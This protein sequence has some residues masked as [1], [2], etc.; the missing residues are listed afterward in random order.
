VTTDQDDLDL[1]D[2]EA[3]ALHD[4]QLG[5]EYVHRAYGSLLEWH[6]NLGHA[7]DR[8][9]DAEA[10]LRKAGH[11]RWADELRDEH[12]PAGAIDDRWTYELVE[13]FQQDFF[14]DVVAF[15]EAVREDVA[16]GVGH[17]TEQQQ[18]RRVRKR[19]RDDE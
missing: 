13:A 17:V 8:M 10:D 19:T 4:L 9:A 7:M 5:I 14:N 11:I 18:Q 2:D 12:I 3:A 16:D 1:T 6:H 15:E